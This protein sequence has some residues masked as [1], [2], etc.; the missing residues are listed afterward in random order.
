MPYYVHNEVSKA[1]V[2]SQLGAQ[3]YGVTGV[4]GSSPTL[5]RLWDNI[6]KVANVGTDT[7]TAI[8]HFDGLAPFNRV[9]CVGDFAVAGGKGAFTVRSYKGDPDFAEDG[10][11]GN[12]VA[13]E[14]DP[15]YYYQDDFSQDNPDYIA[16]TIAVSPTWM[17]GWRPH[18]VC[19]NDDGSIREHTYLPCY[20]LAK[21]DGIACSL[22]GYQNEFGA[23]YALWEAAKTYNTA[24]ILEPSVVRHYEWMLMTIEFAT[25]NMQSVM[26]GASSLPCS[27]SDTIAAA[28]TNVNY[29][30]LTA[31]IGAKFV[32]GMTVYIGAT[33]STTPAALTEYNVITNIQNCLVDGTVDAGGTYR[34]VTFDGLARTVT[35]STTISG[36]PWKTGACNTVLTPSGCPSGATAPASATLYPMRYRYRENVYGN[37]FSTCG[38][39]FSHLS[40]AGTG[41]SPYYID[42]YYLISRLYY[43]ANVN[44]PDFTDL[45]TTAFVKL[46]QETQHAD[47]YI[48]TI[49][50]D[51]TYPCVIT[52]TVQTGGGASTYYADYGYIVNGTVPTR[53][54][55]LGGNTYLGPN[56]GPLYFFADHAPSN[57]YWY[58]GAGLYE[59]Q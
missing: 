11:M 42:W 30:I 55:R 18:P 23:F 8:N 12:Y 6:G 28:G 1:Y 35:A 32:I 7:L 37:Q 16:G 24:A 27:A 54:V 56:A 26:G 17:F 59:A 53:A 22:P 58:Y 31:A 39:L 20:A 38:D 43:P 48:K 44:K 52:P 25:T 34:R 4:G 33:Y 47:G 5:T 13:V 9:K 19:L 29:V 14:V 41:E 2:N 51:N 57:V 50:M 15:F 40:G 45:Q 3:R 10:S 46:A 21:K 36:R 49:A